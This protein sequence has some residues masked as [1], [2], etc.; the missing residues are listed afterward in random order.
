M[1]SGCILPQDNSEHKANWTEKN[2]EE[3]LPWPSLF[4]D[5]AVFY[6]WKIYKMCQE[7]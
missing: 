7:E 3:G 2:S 6:T 4:P 5:L 1:K